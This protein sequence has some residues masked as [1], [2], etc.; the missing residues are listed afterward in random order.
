[1]GHHL[2]LNHYHNLIVST[3]KATMQSY[4][5]GLA[6][7]AGRPAILNGGCHTEQSEARSRLSRHEIPHSGRAALPEVMAHGKRATLSI[8][9][10]NRQVSACT[11][12]Q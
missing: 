12:H 1:M 8:Y 5:W 3:R 6:V 2:P 4:S 10:H 9:Q 11:I 7:I